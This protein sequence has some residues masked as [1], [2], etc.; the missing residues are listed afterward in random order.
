MRLHASYQAQQHAQR[1]QDRHTNSEMSAKVWAVT[2]YNT[3]G[4]RYGYQNLK[5]CQLL[6]RPL[7][8]L[9]LFSPALHAVL[10]ALVGHRKMLM[11]LCAAALPLVYAKHGSS[12]CSSSSS[13]SSSSSHFD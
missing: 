5:H 1:W 4:F 9:S 12:H 13:S 8:L 10:S 3:Q 2:H 7:T 11:S 6:A